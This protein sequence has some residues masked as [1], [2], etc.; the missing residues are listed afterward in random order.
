MLL[1][2]VSAPLRAEVYDIGQLDLESQKGKVVYVDFWASWCKPC[3]ESSPW[4]NTLLDKYPAAGFTVITINLDAGTGEMQRFL[5][6]VPARF[7]ICHDSSGAIA[8]KFQFE[9]MLMDADALDL[10]YH[11]HIYFSKE[12]CSG[13]QG[14]AGGGGN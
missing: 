6:R 13:G 3:R 11:G 14:F 12:A 10:A 1:L 5:D 4:M 7:D 9:G 8:E 2:R